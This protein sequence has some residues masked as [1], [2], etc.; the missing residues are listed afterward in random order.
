MYFPGQIPN[1]VEYESYTDSDGVVKAHIDPP[2]HVL[3]HGVTADASSHTAV[4]F[5]QGCWNE[6]RD[7]KV[8]GPVGST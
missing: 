2:K 4:S 1:L 5:S 8:V 7:G 6:D 3:D